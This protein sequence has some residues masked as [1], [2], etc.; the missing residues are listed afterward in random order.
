V[1]WLAAARPGPS[2][3]IDPADGTHLDMVERPAE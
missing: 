3:I 1:G 2:T